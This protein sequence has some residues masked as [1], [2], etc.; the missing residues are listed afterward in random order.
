MS[1]NILTSFDPDRDERRVDNSKFKWFKNYE[2]QLLLKSPIGETT[3]LF[4][5]KVIFPLEPDDFIKPI[6]E[7][8]SRQLSW[9]I[10][11]AK[12]ELLHYFSTGASLICTCPE[13]DQ[14]VY[15]ITYMDHF[16]EIR[17]GE[18]NTLKYFDGNEEFYS[19]TERVFFR[20]RLFM[21]WLVLKI[22]F[23]KS[24]FD[25]NVIHSED[26]KC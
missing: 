23:Q 13:M 4:K 1:A 22:N 7:Y 9:P 3:P 24:F 25:L 12:N 2:Y 16:S 21:A 10:E 26:T 11:K 6:I 17:Y 19:F 5:C 15:L 20:F 18:P 14:K 8:Y